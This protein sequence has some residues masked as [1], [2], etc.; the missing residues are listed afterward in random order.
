MASPVFR[1]LRVHERS[2]G[3]FEQQVETVSTD[4]LPD[5]P[6]TIR[7][8]WSSLN[9]KDALSASGNKGVTR[10]YPHTPGI[11]AAGVVLESRSPEFQFGEEVVVTGFDLGA[12]TPGGYGGIIR[13]PAEWVVRRPAGLTL[14]GCM[15]YGT[16]GFTAAQSVLRLQDNGVRPENG[17]VLVTGAS[18]GVGS[19]AVGILSRIGYE[20]AAG[21]GKPQARKLLEEL[22]A[23]TF[24]TREELNGPAGKPLQ[25]EK[26]AGVVDTAGGNILATALKSTRAN[27]SV[28]ACGLVQGAEL[29]LT[30]FPFILRGVSLLGIDSVH[31]PRELRQKIWNLLAGEW[32]PEALEKLVQEVTL[33]QLPGKIKAILEGQVTGRTVVQ[34]A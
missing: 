5:H 20:V 26:W 17:P 34:V 13:V 9:Y 16:A 23:R 7:V 18:G 12:N 15:I 21:T 19:I 29:N 14:R 6:V 2:S 10:Q 33:D 25:A 1:A 4:L 3:Q 27:G 30:V 8:Q 22:G 32:R 31:C 28:A 11:D 24:L